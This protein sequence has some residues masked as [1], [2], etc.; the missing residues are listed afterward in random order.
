MLYVIFYHLAKFDTQPKKME[1][2]YFTPQ[3]MRV[4]THH[5]QPMKMDF[6]P[7]GQITP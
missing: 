5:P 2:V 6:L 1:K 3:P 4:E 7:L